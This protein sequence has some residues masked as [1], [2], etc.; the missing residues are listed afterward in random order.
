LVHLLVLV[1]AVLTGVALRRPWARA[2]ALVLGAAACLHPAV[3][4]VG[5]PPLFTPIASDTGLWRAGGAAVLV[6]GP[7]ATEAALLGGLRRS[8]TRRV[9]IVVFT[10]P[11]SGAP[12]QLAAVAA[13]AVVG[14]VYASPE[15]ALVG[16]RAPPLTGDLAVGGLLVALRV[17]GADLEAQ[18]TERAG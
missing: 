17:R 2:A 6:V 7:R 15:A 10:E 5:T 16:S 9:D 13:R 1:A 4:L 18:I 14:A 8:G 11:R 12:D 3:A